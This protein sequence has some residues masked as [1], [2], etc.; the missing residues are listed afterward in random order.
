MASRI[1]V[2]MRASATASLTAG[3]IRAMDFTFASSTT[4]NGKLKFYSGE[5]AFTGKPLG[6]GFFGCGGA[7]HVPGLQE[8]L[9]HIGYAGY[10]HHVSVTPGNWKRAV[11]EAF[12]R[13]LGYEQTQI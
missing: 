12:T 8:K 10:R 3:S 4:Q 9:V 11:D 7:A 1:F 6:E 2:G 5:G 13:Y